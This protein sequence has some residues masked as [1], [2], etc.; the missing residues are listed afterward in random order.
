MRL[1]DLGP[2]P[3]LNYHRNPIQRP[4]AAELKN[5][6][7]LKLPYDWNFDI[8]GISHP[9]GEKRIRLHTQADCDDGST[10]RSN[11][12]S[13]D[14]TLRTNDN[15]ILASK[16]PRGPSPPVV[17]IKPIPISPR[18]PSPVEF[19]EQDYMTS[20]SS[21][22][23]RQKSSGRRK[24]KYRVANPEDDEGVPPNYQFVPSPLP[25]VSPYSARL[26]ASSKY[27]SNYMSGNAPEVNPLSHS[28]STPYLVPTPQIPSLSKYLSDFHLSNSSS[29][30][31][32]PRASSG[33]VDDS[34][35]KRPPI[36]VHPPNSSAYSSSSSSHKRGSSSFFPTHHF[37]ATQPQMTLAPP[38]P[39]PTLPNS[40]ISYAQFSPSDLPSSSCNITNPSMTKKLSTQS[41]LGR[42]NADDVVQ[43]LG[44]YF[45]NRD[46]DQ[47]IVV[48]SPSIN[49]TEKESTDRYYYGDLVSAR[50]ND[51]ASGPSTSHQH[52]VTRP[53]TGQTSFPC[54]SIPTRFSSSHRPEYT[55]NRERPGDLSNLGIDSSHT[56]HHCGNIAAT[57]TLA[58]PDVR[59]ERVKTIRQVAEE[60]QLNPNKAHRR[61]LWDIKMEE[62]K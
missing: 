18:P 11:G 22:S 52:R 54:P 4:S 53:I 23:S 39:T 56:D 35:W 26:A 38:P 59:L 55:A 57:P 32:P 13:Q 19:T 61:T 3:R 29:T 5:H 1:I 15:S 49:L 37:Q 45:P 12:D 48:Q 62:V 34:T 33:M 17:I 44:T 51:I 25:S 30:T 50:E 46:L 60:R 58:H 40:K 24:Y 14:L 47:P 7:Y 2:G 8:N 41:A 36:T 31:S 42:P 28:D 9:S 27:D 6:T 10:C 16:I 43:H 21:T 20:G